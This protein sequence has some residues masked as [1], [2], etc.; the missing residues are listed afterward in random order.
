MNKTINAEAL[1]ANGISTTPLSASRKVYASSPLATDIRVPFR[2]I[3]ID[4]PNAPAFRVY[5]TSGPYTD[6][7][8]AIDLK[9]GLPRLREDW[10]AKRGDAEPYAGRAIR[11]ED[12]GHV[13]PDRAVAHFPLAHRPLRGLA[14]R[15]ITQLDYARAGI[16]TKEM[17]F[18]AERENLGRQQVLEGAE[19]RLADGNSFGAAIPPFITPEFVRDEIARGRAIIPANINHPEIEPM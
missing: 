2:E 1:S 10:I 11:P 14:G 17:I 8:I 19:A 16:I 5:D 4:D 9:R 13:S 12:D 15:P 18:V 6:P 3:A 7:A